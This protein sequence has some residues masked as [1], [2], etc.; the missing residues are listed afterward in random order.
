MNLHSKRYP[1]LYKDSVSLMQISAQLGRIEGV[2]QANVAMATEANMARMREANMP[3]EGAPAPGDLLIALLAQDEETAAKAFAL[4]GELL[5]PKRDDAGGGGQRRLPLTSLGMA[6]ERHPSANLALISVPGRYAAAETRKALGLGLNVMLFS[7]NVDEDD[8]IDLKKEAEAR[9]LLVMGPDCGTAIVNGL[10]LGFA[11]VARRG[12]IGVVGASGTGLQEVTCAIHHLGEG[13]SQAIGTGGRDLHEGVDGRTMRQAIRMLAAD[14]QTEQIVLISKPPAPAVAAKVLEEARRCGKPT[15]VH[16]LGR[17]DVAAGEGLVGAQN[18]RHA[19]E[20]AVALR[21]GAPIPAPAP[22]PEALLY[23]ARRAAQTLA[24]SQRFVRGVFA[25][26]TFCYEAQLTLLGAGLSC[27][28]NA[29]APGATRLREAARGHGH[30]LVDM[31]DDMFTEGRPHPM[32]DP[33][34]RDAR[35]L[36]EAADPETA[37]LLF[38]VVLGY[39]ADA[40]P[41]RGLIP[42][43]A[44]AQASARAGGRDLV[45]IAHVCGTELDPQSRERVVQTLRDAG[46]LV[47][48]SNVE[49]AAL[50]AHVVAVIEKERA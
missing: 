41:C 14:P 48:E 27:E 23:A 2:G 39:G 26:G 12:A 13:V 24:P 25:G 38:D 30:S 17:R 44:Q 35:L 18:L 7:D 31:G 32:I 28:S 3:V 21:R 33:S 20:V 11:N 22:L 46:V 29:P 36:S 8:E 42:I 16:F 9:D 6:L 10:P 40:D 37:V 49:A 47:A 45:V 1:N 34:L 4:A 43:L 50:A 15:V 5:A 19:A